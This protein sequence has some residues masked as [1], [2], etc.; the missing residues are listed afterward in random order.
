MGGDPKIMARRLT[1][2]RKARG[3][4]VDQIVNYLI[5]LRMSTKSPKKRRLWIG[6]VREWFHFG[7]DEIPGEF[8]EDFNRIC[9]LLSIPSIEALW[10]DDS[11]HGPDVD[12]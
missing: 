11:G 4:T 3:L 6:T 12:T 5:E 8:R 7:L 2:A 9:R 10:V 1:E